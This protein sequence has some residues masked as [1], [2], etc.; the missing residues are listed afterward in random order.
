MSVEL[1]IKVELTQP[2]EIK[3]VCERDPL[4]IKIER[5][6]QVLVNKILTEVKRFEAIGDNYSGNST[7]KYNAL[8]GALDGN[9]KTFTL[10]DDQ[11]FIANTAVV[12]LDGQ[13]ITGF[14]PHDANDG[15]EFDNA[16]A[17]DSCIHIDCEIIP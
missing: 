4:E 9:N 11:V 14:T 13:R 6:T 5:E 3:V 7:P 17:D 1:D 8:I 10:P 16:P 2:L 15:V 12:Y